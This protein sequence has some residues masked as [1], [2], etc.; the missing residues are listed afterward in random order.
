MM[1]RPSFGPQ[2]DAEV[3]ILSYLNDSNHTDSEKKG[4]LV[5]ELLHRF[6]IKTLDDTNEV[7]YYQN[8]IYRTGAEAKLIQELEQLGGHLITNHMRNEVL[9]SIK[10]RTYVSRDEFDRNSDILNL[11][12]GLLSISTGQF[13]VHTHEYLSLAQLPAKYDP[14]ATC[15]NIMRF[16]RSTLDT[17]QFKVVVRL[18]GYILMRSTQYE[19]AFM[20][21]GEGANGK[22]TFINLL[23][24]FVGRENASSVSLQ[25]LTQDRFAL[26]ELHKKMIN[27]F[28]DLKTD[29]I[30][31][32]GHFKTLVTG[33]RI[34]AQRKHQQHF[35][36]VNTAKLIFSANRIPETDDKSYSY[37][38]RWVII[39]FGKTFEGSD[40]DEHLIHKLTT[41]QELSGL[42]NVALVGL[43]RL[44]TDGGF[45]DTDIE[46]IRRQYELG[47]SKIQDF[48]NDHCQLD[49][50]ND[51]L[52]ITTL[53]LQE[54]FSKYC[55]EKGTGYVD[56]RELGERIKALGV[57]KER[58][59]VKGA[60]RPYFYVGISLKPD[61]P[62][63]PIKQNTIL[64]SGEN[65][66]MPEVVAGQI[67]T[68]GHNNSRSTG[69]SGESPNL[70]KLKSEP[71]R[72][73]LHSD[74]NT[75]EAGE[76]LSMLA[77]ERHDTFGP[78]DGSKSNSPGSISEKIE[79]SFGL[80][81]RKI[82]AVSIKRRSYYD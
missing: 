65:T 31:D 61:C 73:N 42:L 55:K 11:A 81:D 38:R 16:L 32:T 62:Y 79:S 10:A 23:T 4:A 52:R 46:D 33:D 14:K 74:C 70:S 3:A 56:I 57:R 30:S 49:V 78:S 44:V 9:A 36:F 45:E 20:L 17:E 53:D 82:T 29:K 59:R 39:P 41:E 19:K 21:V 64:V 27:V 69:Y 66:K 7:L 80:T 24:A 54:A 25:D 60:D 8:G 22:S 67:G 5:E 35:S 12:T 34:R 40:R 6:H 43:K 76:V 63:V 68:L 26:A 50:D 37:F 72:N 77:E 75:V 47:A 15:P 28:A 58:R 13:K 2:D 51:D 18:L 71:I 1:A 48:I